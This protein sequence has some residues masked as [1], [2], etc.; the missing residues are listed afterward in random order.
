MTYQLG[1]EYRFEGKDGKVYTKAPKHALEGWKAFARTKKGTYREV[2]GCS[3]EQEGTWVQGENQ[4]A[5]FCHTHDSRND[6]EM[7]AFKA[8]RWLNK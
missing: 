6:A 1:G 4:G 5:W 2:L 7:Q 8:Y 3:Q